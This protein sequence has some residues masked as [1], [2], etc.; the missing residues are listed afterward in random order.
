MDQSLLK[1]KFTM[2]HIFPHMALVVL[3]RF[4]AF[5]ALFLRP[6]G[7]NI[8]ASPPLR[9]P[10]ND[11]NKSSS[12]QLLNSSSTIPISPIADEDPLCHDFWTIMDETSCIQVW[13]TIPND[14][15][16]YL[17]RIPIYGDFDFTLPYR[18][19]SGMDFPYLEC[20]M[21]LDTTNTNT[22]W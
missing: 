1:R 15:H 20:K 22:G 21:H 19:S 5:S 18:W 7:S 11:T 17:F 10:M 6:V 13:Q 3:L 14:P 16:V 9:L 2:A 8:A 4:A 12:L